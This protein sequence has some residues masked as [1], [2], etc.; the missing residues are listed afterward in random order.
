M[1]ECEFWVS[2]KVDEETKFLNTQSGIIESQKSE[3]NACKIH[4][5][6]Y[7]PVKANKFVDIWD[8]VGLGSVVKEETTSH[9][10]KANKMISKRLKTMIEW[11]K[12]WCV[13]R[14]YDWFSGMY[15][16]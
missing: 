10:N 13:N 2:K 12:S 4:Y 7:L 9:N 6:P 15:K 16:S 5:Y 14:F 8:F 1:D 11:L 3:K